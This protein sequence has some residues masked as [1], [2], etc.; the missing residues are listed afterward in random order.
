MA[1][2][3]EN[4][5]QGDIFVRKAPSCSMGDL[6]Q[7]LKN[8]FHS[9]SEIKTIGMRHGEKMYETLA[10][11]GELLRSEDLDDYLRVSID[12][13]DLNY[14]KYLYEGDKNIVGIEDYNS[15]NTTRMTLDEIERMLLAQPEVISQLEN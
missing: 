9:K 4:A 11:R 1:F 12:G 7:A 5:R 10:S 6:A 13:R 8:I 2:A 3:L 14:N 15:E